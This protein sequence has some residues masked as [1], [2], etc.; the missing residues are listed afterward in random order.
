[1]NLVALAVTYHQAVSRYEERCRLCTARRRPAA[2]RLEIDPHRVELFKA[3]HF[4]G[5]S[6]MAAFAAAAATGGVGL[7]A[8]APDRRDSLATKSLT[9]PGSR[10]AMTVK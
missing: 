2:L 9:P 4:E 3:T 8:V 1:L 10:T 5:H 6:A 7:H